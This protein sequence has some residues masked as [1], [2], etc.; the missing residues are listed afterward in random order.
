MND[1]DP[2]T[3][4]DTQKSWPFQ[5]RPPAPLEILD[6][7]IFDIDA[8]SCA[9]REATADAENRTARIRDDL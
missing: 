1:T 9:V 6:M 4:A 3:L 2:R 8:Q 7:A 5:K